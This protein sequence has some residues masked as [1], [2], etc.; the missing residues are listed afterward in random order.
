[1]TK[2]TK[3]HEQQTAKGGSSAS[4]IYRTRQC[5]KMLNRPCGGNY[6]T[7]CGFVNILIDSL[8]RG[9]WI[10]GSCFT[11]HISCPGI[12]VIVVV[13]YSYGRGIR[14]K[15]AEILSV[16]ENVT[17]TDVEEFTPGCI[18]LSLHVSIIHSFLKFQSV[19]DTTFPCFHRKSKSKSKCTFNSK[20]NND[21]N[22][23]LIYDRKTGTAIITAGTGFHCVFQVDYGDHDHVFTGI[24]KW[25]RKTVDH[26]LIGDI[27]NAAGGANGSGGF[28]NSGGGGS[29][30]T[31]SGS[32]GSHL[33]GNANGQEETGAR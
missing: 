31:R 16:V 13:G 15:D 27:S 7:I 25:Y 9:I 8:Q 23:Y 33:H 20:C 32:G 22:K 1:M 29:D 17:L 4:A 12:G 18:E 5:R 24:Q 3:R 6:E 2:N 30:G 19:S 11:V 28:S 26:I 10:H 21:N 14:R